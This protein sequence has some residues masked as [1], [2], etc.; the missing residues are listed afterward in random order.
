[1]EKA[2]GAFSLQALI[3]LEAELRNVDGVILLEDVPDNC[4]TN[5]RNKKFVQR[6]LQDLPNLFWVDNGC[7][8]HILYKLISATAGEDK[9]TGHVHAARLVLGIAARRQLVWE[10]LWKI[11]DAEF[12]MIEGEPPEEVA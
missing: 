1:M 12:E 6:Q 10:P 8:A 2:S 4:R 5:L 11:V 7:S 9:L 3:A